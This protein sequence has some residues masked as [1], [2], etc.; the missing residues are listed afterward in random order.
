[1]IAYISLPRHSV[2][3]PF[4]G[5]DGR[6]HDFYDAECPLTGTM[7]LIL[8]ANSRQL[9]CNQTQSPARTS[10]KNS[11]KKNQLSK[12]GDK[13][14]KIMAASRHDDP[15]KSK[16]SI[17]RKVSTR[18]A[19]NLRQR[20][21]PASIWGHKKDIVSQTS[22]LV[23]GGTQNKMRDT[24]ASILKREVNAVASLMQQL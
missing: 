3:R 9:V 6:L 15:F 21:R 4:V 12:F 18:A 1:M 14:L 19:Q 7:S 8:P 23:R 10:R 16:R 5:N 20:V 24:D 2:V 11:R 22:R 13:H 17:G